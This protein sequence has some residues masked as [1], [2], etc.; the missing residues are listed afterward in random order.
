MCSGSR[1]TIGALVVGLYC[2]CSDSRPTVSAVI[3]GLLFE[4]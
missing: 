4:P 3:V 1:P 2:Y